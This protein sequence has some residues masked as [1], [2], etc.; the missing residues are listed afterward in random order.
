VSCLAPQGYM[1]GLALVR[2][3]KRMSRVGEWRAL[4][5]EDGTETW[6]CG[7]VTGGEDIIATT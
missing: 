1:A 6:I 2:S 3:P 4:K 7:H 5:G